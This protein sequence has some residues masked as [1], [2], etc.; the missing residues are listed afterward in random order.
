MCVACWSVEGNGAE[1]GQGQLGPAE[2]LGHFLTTETGSALHLLGCRATARAA[3]FSAG[4]LLGVSSKTWLC[5]RAYALGHPRLVSMSLALGQVRAVFLF[6]TCELHICSYLGSIFHIPWAEEPIAGV[7]VHCSVTYVALSIM[8]AA[9]ISIRGLSG[10]ADPP[11]TL[12]QEELENF[13]LPTV[14]HSQT[15]LNQLR[16]PSVLLLVCQDSDQNKPDIHF[17]HCDEVEVRQTAR[18]GGHDASWPS[19]LDT[20]M[21]PGGACAGRHRECPG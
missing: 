18:G 14:Q 8:L 13:P 9:Y 7:S 20:P 21:S 6:Y 2:S 19:R 11:Y 10:K 17:F 16:Y 15:V 3:L 4:A 12:P 1:G 5:P